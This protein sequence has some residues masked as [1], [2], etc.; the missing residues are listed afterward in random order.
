MHGQQSLK[1][2]I[3][4]CIQMENAAKWIQY[5]FIHQQHLSAPKFPEMAE[6]SLAG[7]QPILHPE[8]VFHHLTSLR[9]KTDCTEMVHE[10][11][12]NPALKHLRHLHLT[13]WLSP[14]S[15]SG[16]EYPALIENAINVQT[17]TVAPSLENMAEQVLRANNRT[18]E[19]I[20]MSPAPPYDEESDDG[21][22]FTIVIVGD[23]DDDDF[24]M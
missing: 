3:G 8:A 17:L 4:K 19:L 11:L 9:L 14:P 1:L 21:G 5:R 7:D 13:G 18:T 6:L 12:Q 20:V 15:S 22:C 24:P 10:L 23:D 16:V 2:R